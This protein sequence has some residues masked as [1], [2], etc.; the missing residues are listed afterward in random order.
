M[1]R[2]VYVY[3]SCVARDTF[4]TMS[5]TEYSLVAYTARHSILADQTDAT[6]KLPDDLGLSSAFQAR[7][8]RQDWEGKELQAIVDRADDIDL[9]LWDLIDERHGV[10]WFPT[11][12]V[13]TR[14]IDLLQSE[15]A[16]DLILPDTRI[17]FGSELHFDG[18][19]E[20]A[21]E[22]VETL[23]EN[24]LLKKTRLVRINWATSAPDG[25][26]T[27]ASMGLSAQEANVL[28]TRYYDHLESLG[29]PVITVPENITYADPGH[30]WGFAA[31]HYTPEVYAFIRAEIEKFFDARGQ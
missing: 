9:L 11:G 10:H 30:Q 26:P 2:G 23:K 24:Q 29:V 8:V 22:V 25:T 27:P 15:P 21:A 3:G 31:F 13:V 5:D 1:S 19:A 7:M 4:S 18:W 28:Y 12:E 16:M 20:K 14:S 17:S 6:Y